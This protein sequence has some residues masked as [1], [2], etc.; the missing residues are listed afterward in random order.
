MAAGEDNR[1]TPNHLINELPTIVK[2]IHLT[3]GN[4]N[5]ELLANGKL[6]A[7]RKANLKFSGDGIIS[8]INVKENDRVNKGQTLAG[9]DKTAQLH[10]YNQAKLRYRQAILDYE[11]QLLRLG[12]RLTDTSRID[13]NTQ[14]IAKIRSGLSSAQLELQKAKADFDNTNLIAPFSGN[15]ANLKGRLYNNASSSEYFCTLINDSELTVEFLILEQELNF[16]RNA[17]TVMIVPFNNEHKRYTGIITSV[18]PTID[19]S[20]M[21][22]VKARVSNTGLELIDGMSVKIKVQ[23]AI[24]KQLIIPK[25]A[26]LERQGRKVVFTRKNKTAFWNYV[27]VAYENSNEFAIKSGLKPGDEVIYDGNFNLAHNKPIEVEN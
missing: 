25:T 20:G 3:E 4:F 5:R 23:Q 14:T 2:T 11:D 17:N 27:E 13:K 19:K 26:L 9:L 8:S 16:I 1:N 22:S 21:L 6:E 15:I 12:F 7:S 24:H 18:N 10:S